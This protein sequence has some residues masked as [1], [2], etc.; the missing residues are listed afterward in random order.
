MSYIQANLLKNEKV[1]YFT[2]M[3]WIV[4]TFPVVLLVAT[5]ILAS[6]SPVLFRGYVPFLNIRMAAVVILLCLFAHFI[7]RHQRT[8]P[9]CDF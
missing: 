4:F 8:D 5:F 7:F 9:L 3:H 2:R 1:V 6:V